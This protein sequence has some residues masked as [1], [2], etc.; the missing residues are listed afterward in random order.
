MYGLLHGTR[1]IEGA[2]FIAAPFCALSLAQLG[3][4]VIRFDPVGGGPDFHRWPRCPGGGSFYWEGLNKSKKSIAINLSNPRGRELAVALV[5]A[6]GD[7]A[8]IFVTNYPVA[9]FL[10]HDRLVSRRPDLIT[11]RIMGH[12]D[13]GNAVDYTVNCAM[14]IPMMTGPADN[15]IPVNH[16]LPAWDLL[17]GSIAATSVLA[18]LI[19]RHAT[20][21]GQEVRVP[22]SDVA[23]ATLGT[24]GQVAEVIVNGRDRP[25]IGNDLFGAFGRDFVTA[26]GQRLMIVAITGRQ[27]GGL[28]QALEIQAEVASLEA[29]L[30]VSFAEDEGLRYEY[31]DRLG[32]LVA[33]VVSASSA[34]QLTERLDE[35]GACW[36]P[37]RTVSE[38]VAREKPFQPEGQLFTE[39]DHVSGYTYP[40]PGYPATFREF[41]R[42]APTR[43]PNLGEH[44]EE[45][46]AG[47]LALPSH[48]IAALH[49]SGVVQSA[50]AKV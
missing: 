15:P 26:D 44:T 9:G 6:P 20:G 18:A 27:W 36:G 32:A 11:A 4:E 35:A 16:V 14:G 24:L 22:L 45:V 19:S 7:G 41:Q 2:S 46:L 34:A 47:V 40:T 37:Y 30:G 23:A 8:G 25:K 12:A 42:H 31:R 28:V 29:E 1:V 33:H 38:A 49:D 10:S 43:A 48:E 39:V 13:G 3:A 17:T 5:T 50:G 21:L